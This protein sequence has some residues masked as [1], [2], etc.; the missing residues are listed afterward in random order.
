MSGKNCY[1][2]MKLG[3]TVLTESEIE[4]F[5]VRVYIFKAKHI[6]EGRRKTRNVYMNISVSKRFF[7]DLQP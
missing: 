3:L 1:S 5:I 2:D 6:S 7:L 4:A